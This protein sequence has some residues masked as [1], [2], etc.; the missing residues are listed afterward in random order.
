MK[1]KQS[2]L[3]L[4]AFSLLVLS[5]KPPQGTSGDTA[6]FKPEFN[7]KPSPAYLSPQES[8]KT[9]HVPAGY[10]LELVASEP[11]IKEPVAIAW[12][13]NGRLYVAEMLTY[14]QDANASGERQ[15]ISR[16]TRLEDTN[17][18]GK[19]DKSSVF[20][21]KLL[22]PRM[23]QCVN[24][25][26][27]VN[28]T[29]TINIHSYRDTDGDGKADQKK[30][31]Y[32]NDKYDVNGANMEHQRS[33][34]DWNL[35]N[36]MYL[37]YDPI[38]FRYTNGTMQIDTITSG[39][40][41]QWGVT[42][43]D[44]GRIYYSR[45]GGE[46]PASGFQIN[47]VYGGLEFPDQ[48]S[49]K[50]QEV[51]PIIATPDVQGGFPRLRPDVTLNHFTASCG[52][53]IYRGDRLPADLRGD[54]IVCEP[55]ARIIRRAKVINNNGKTTLENAYDRQEFISSSDMNF[56]PVNT[57]TGPDGNLYIVDMHRGIIQQGN[58]TKP[59]SFLR[60]RIDSLGLDKNVG[61]G[62]IYRLVHNSTARTKAPKPQL[63]NQSS[64][65]LLTYLDHPNG[66]WRDNAQK[67][68]IVKQDK[69][70]VTALK[71]IIS[72]GPIG[73][74]KTPSHLARIHA[75]WT[76]EGLEAVDKEILITALKDEHPQVRRTAV[77]IS[78]P[79][80]K[81]NNAQMLAEV[82]KLQN[83]PNY[84]VRV[85][86]LLSLYE[87]KAPAAK[88]ITKQILDQNTNIEMLVATQDAL[89]KNENT[90]NY[91]SKLANLPAADRSLILQ[92][93]ATF[94]SLCASC[95]GADGKGLAV[96][97]S[98]MAAP[99]LKDSKRLAFLEKNTAI[100]IVM[101]G[102]SGPVD[103]KTYASVMPS[104]SANSDEWIAGV[105]SYI[106]HE[107]GG[108]PPRNY[109]GVQPGMAPPSASK[110]NGFTI[111]PTV[112]AAVTPEEVKKIRTAHASRTKTW[113]LAELE[114]KS[115]DELTIQ[116]TTGSSK[117]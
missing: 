43:D 117:Q 25:E 67:Q 85:Q 87:S 62:R 61:H 77:W 80:L 111:R 26:L 95:H 50:F 11:M 69:S 79:Y 114:A 108:P 99:P 58:W 16:I 59:G 112:S 116:T 63:L 17:N 73:K 15:P 33:G 89:V 39:S 60:Q 100:R 97:G 68:I 23:I 3:S 103:G 27:L 76:L 46:I 2:F 8:M 28:E 83:D 21:D 40:G 90:K 102:L 55:V 88:A 34:L 30:L 22:L 52:Q 18:D 86:L 6:N 66:W 53:S 9:I 37:T 4:L 24:D 1:K 98:S 106:R 104:M 82:A 110:A 101:H 107:F 91:G 81:Q 47:P 78:E 96:A 75:L 5:C 105:V 115:K 36:W 14:M 42:H 35:D 70:V 32:Q 94:K 7:P 29:N 72:G 109:G 12:D 92:G 51:W 31:V 44:Y 54:Y 19:M 84:D 49:A 113:T 13:G 10:K 65:E 93:A 45:A 71:S 48:Y 74:F 38:R 20:I 57:A 56:R 64:S 41:G